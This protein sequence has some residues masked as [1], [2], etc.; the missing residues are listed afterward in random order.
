MKI[1]EKHKE[2]VENRGYIYVYTYSYK[3][4]TIDKHKYNDK[5]KYI[6]VECPYCGTKYDI[7]LVSFKNGDNCTNCCNKYENSFAYHIQVELGKPLNKYWDWERNTVNPYLISKNRN[8]KNSKGENLKVWIKCTEKSYHESYDIA[9]V[10]FAQRKDR[11]PY[12]SNRLGKVHPLDSYGALYP[13]KSKYWN[14]ELNEKTPF[15]IPPH[16]AKKYWHNCEECGKAIL[17]HINNLNRYDNGVKCDS[18]C[19]KSKGEYKINKKLLKFNID[20]VPQKEFKGL[21][22]LRGGNLSYDF[23]LPKYN[24]LI[25]YQGEFHDGTAQFQTDKEFEM[26]QEHDRRKRE[27]ANNHNIKLLEIW[28]WD[29][30]NIEEILNRELQL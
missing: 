20:Y 14:Y 9:C 18:C 25:E 22:G 16:T 11:C 7:T 23:Y 28:Y 13:E 10:K 4:Y 27:Y 30:D 3:E 8:A 17:K 12:C 2:I 26:Q 15:D 24:L 19:G 1:V 29:F 6:R 21:V 5:S